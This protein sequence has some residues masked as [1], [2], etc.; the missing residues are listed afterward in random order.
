MKVIIAGSRTMLDPKH[1]ES[2]VKD[3]QFDITEIVSG[4]AR[5]ADFLGEL[6]GE[7]Y[8]IPVKRFPADWDMYGKAA[9]YKRNQQMADYADALILVWDGKS[10]GSG[11]MLEIAKRKGLKIYQKIVEC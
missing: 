10:R 7:Y 6:Y 1:I 8:G 5:G 2:A 11:H 3:S 4:T 9:G